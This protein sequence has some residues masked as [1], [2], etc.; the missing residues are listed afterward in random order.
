MLYFS[1]FLRLLSLIVALMLALMVE[2]T[3][4]IMAQ[5]TKNF[6]RLEWRSIGPAIFA[7]RVTDVEGVPGNP[8]I[9]YVAS[10]SGGLWKTINGGITWLPVFER[11]GTISLGD[12]AIDP[13]NPEVI[14][15]G[16][17]EANPR[18]SVSFGDGIYR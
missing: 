14:W 11:Q 6:E 5:E 3:I 1:G 13:R 16:T 10:A 7:G 2:L 12:I 8:R 4:P 15:A 18:N 17:G 9:L